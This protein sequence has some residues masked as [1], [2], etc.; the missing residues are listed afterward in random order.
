M[1][2]PSLHTKKR[3]KSH[4]QITANENKKFEIENEQENKKTKIKVGTSIFVFQ[5]TNNLVSYMSNKYKCVCNHVS[6]AHDVDQ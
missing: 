6:S 4:F 3:K 1:V 5:K 2:L